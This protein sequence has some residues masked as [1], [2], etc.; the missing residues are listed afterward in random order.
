MF[1]HS[2]RC[3]W[4]RV[5]SESGRSIRPHRSLSCLLGGLLMSSGMALPPDA[6]RLPGNRDLG[7]ILNNDINNILYV[8]SG[9]ETTAPEYRK[10]VLHLLDAEPG[11]LAQNV[12]MPDPVI[13]RTGVA[14]TWDKYVGGDQAAATAALL[15]AGTDPFAI[16]VE[17]CRQRGVLVV[18][19]YR[20]N[21]EDFYAGQL[22]LYDFGREH[23]DLRIPGAHCLDPVHPEVYSH[24]MA[25]FREVAENYDIDGIEFDFRRWCHMVSNPAENHTVLTRMVRDTRAMLDEVAARKGRRRLL[26]GARVAPTIAGP[27]F[28]R[29]D[30]SCQDLGLDVETW[31]RD[32]LVDYLCP[33]FF[34]G[35]N[36]NDNPQTAEFAKLAANTDVGIYPTVF[37]R[38]KWQDENAEAERIGLDEPDAMRRFRDELIQAALHAY[39]AGADGISTFNWVPHHQPGMTRKNLRE[40]WG[41]GAAKVQMLVHPLFGDP[42]ALRSCL[43]ADRLPAAE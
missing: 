11:V 8:V 16:T 21:A 37:P 6:R 42:D 24:R 3:R 23:K 9:A 12:G 7:T 27:S 22:D 14:T 38:S 18:A 25:I 20:M 19:S 34:W 40:S 32:A 10:A 29:S 2:K 5:Q 17:A 4:G 1:R 35:R 36:P 43:K 15:A 33:S 28:G 41:L 39:T 13:Y 31:I 26:L 30:M